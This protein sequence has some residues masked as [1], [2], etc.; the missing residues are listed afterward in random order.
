MVTP[1]YKGSGERTLVVDHLK[2]SY[3]GL[4][5]AGE[6]F[7]VVQ[8][9]FFEKGYDW[10]EKMNSEV[11][12]PQ[13][14]Q[15]RLVLEPWKCSSEHHKIEMRV[16]ILMLNIKEVDVENKGERLRLNHGEIKMTF[17]A[18]VFSDRRG[19]WS[20]QPLYW[21]LLILFEKYFYHHHVEKFEIWVKSDLD[22]LV[23][24]IKEYLNVF[25]YSYQ[26]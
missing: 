12:T 1:N 11:T 26:Q 23:Q 22:H 15:I 20:S 9:F 8:S 10:Y 24:R 16:K 7:A 3:E 6:L 25:K 4:F 21:F 18:F 14:K 2:F 19:T 5:N 17:D 13:G